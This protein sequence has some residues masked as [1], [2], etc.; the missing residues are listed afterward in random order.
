MQIGPVLYCMIILDLRSASLVENLSK[1]DEEHHIRERISAV[2]DP[3]TSI[4]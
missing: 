3:F 2:D 1:K 4:I